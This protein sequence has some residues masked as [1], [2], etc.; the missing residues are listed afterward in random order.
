MDEARLLFSPRLPYPEYLARFRAADLF[1][2]TAPFN[3][4]TTV[5][6]ALWAGLPVLTLSGEAFSSRYGASL[7][8]ALGAPELVTSTPAEYEDA[9]VLLAADTQ[10]MASLKRKVAGGLDASALFDPV[11]FTRNLETGLA[12]IYE[13]DRAGLAPD[14]VWVRE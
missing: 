11:R 7:L 6:D 1:L 5:A 2:D 14:H 8:T 12:A 4:G 3:G 9:A 13:R 10:R